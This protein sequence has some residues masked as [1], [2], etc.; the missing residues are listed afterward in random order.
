MKTQY[1]IA[2]PLNDLFKQ[3][4]EQ[5]HLSVVDQHASLPEQAGKLMSEITCHIIDY[6]FTDM[7]Q[8]FTQVEGLSTQKIASFKE[9]LEQIE[10]IKVIIRKYFSWVVAWFNAKRLTPVIAH[11]YQLITSCHIN[12]VV[13]PCLIFSISDELA[14]K[15]LKALNDLKCVDHHNPNPANPAIHAVECL[16][17]V[18]DV[19]VTKLLKEPK[20]LLK[21]NFVVNKTLDGVITMTTA[22]SYKSLRKLGLAM[23]P[24]L[25][26]TAS[27]HLQQFIIPSPL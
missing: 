22:L 9:S 13:L 3:Q 23:D 26:Q 4:I 27:G 1:A 17:E 18:I 19:G 10:E 25:Y 5:L 12:N 14:A 24:T 6:I 2:L 21:F 11:Y 16:I 8:Q 7:V 15:S 20:E